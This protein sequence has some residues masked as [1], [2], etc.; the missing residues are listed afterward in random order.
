M[1]RMGYRTLALHGFG[2]EM[3]DRKDW[4][5]K[6]GF[7]DIWFHDRLQ[8]AGVPDCDGTF[9]GNC[10]DDAVAAWLGTRLQQ[11]AMLLYLCIRLP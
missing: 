5:P 11:P 2:G 8:E 10:D 4:Y 9:K 1:R 7:E 3:Y 6:M